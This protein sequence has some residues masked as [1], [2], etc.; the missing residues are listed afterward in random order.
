MKL[1]IDKILE[2]YKV[3]GITAKWL[4]NFLL[5][6][7]IIVSV[8]SL[9]IAVLIR[10]YYYNSVKVALESL[11]TNLAQNYFSSYLDTTE[12]QF[13]NGALKFIDEFSEKDKMEVWIIDESGKPLISSSGF[14]IS[15]KPIMPDFDDV[16]KSNK[17]VGEWSGKNEYGERVMALTVPLQN[18]QNGS[19]TSKAAIRY[20]VSV[21][22]IRSQLAVIYLYV[23][24]VAIVIIL[25]ITVSGRYFIKSIVTPVEELSKAVKKVSSGDYTVRVEYSKGNDEIRSLCSNINSMLD[26]ISGMDR[27]KNDFISTISH[28][29]RTPLTA[30]KGWG[31]TL[32]QIGDKDPVMLQKGL[33]VIINE[34]GRLSELVEELLDFSRLQ[35][36]VLKIKREK[37][38]V[39]AEL[40]ETVFVFR[41]RAV[42]EGIDFVYTAPEEPAPMYADPNR[43]K[44]VFTNILDNALKYTDQGGKVIVNALI[45]S[46]GYLNVYFVDTGCGISQEDLPKVKEKFYKTSINYRGSGIGLAVVDEIV[47]LHDGEVKISSTLGEGTT[48]RLILPLEKIQQTLNIVEKEQNING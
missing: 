35:N 20:I 38:D 19:Y 32:L 42:R 40:D 7:I 28:E 3:K 36:G 47:R 8:V 17:E 25:L 26:E 9:T 13:K 37:I 11:D 33:E 12:E 23:L 18:P 34:S 14:E 5:V 43:I 31:E 24:I 1:K 6:S 4:K 27:M 15:E 44:Q 46:D 21:E 48:V 10:W 22:D 45:T 39:L 16:F 41:D 2:K 29:I 30:V